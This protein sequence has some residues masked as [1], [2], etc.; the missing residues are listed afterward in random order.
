MEKNKIIIIS[1]A[2]IKSLFY[3]IFG[4]GIL[5]IGLLFLFNKIQIPGILFIV[6]GGLMMFNIIGFFAKPRNLIFECR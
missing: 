4:L 6:F 5:L 3:S 1:Q 2:K